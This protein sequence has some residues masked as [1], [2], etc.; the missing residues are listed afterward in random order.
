MTKQIFYVLLAAS[1]LALPQTAYASMSEADALLGDT[2]PFEV[3]FNFITGPL[4]IFIAVAAVVVFG[5]QIISGNEMGGV[6]R[7]LPQL[8]IG[9]A[10]IL[11]AVRLISVL[12]G[13]TGMILTTIGPF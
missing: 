4:A 3:V 9:V 8:L 11:G 12:T 10:F 2:N 1:I 6:M 13:S 5:A 7:R